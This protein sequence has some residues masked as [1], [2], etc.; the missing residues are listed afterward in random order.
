MIR[1][2]MS[3]ANDGNYR[4]LRWFSAWTLKDKLVDFQL[5]TDVSEIV[6]QISAPFGYAYIQFL[7]T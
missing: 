5:P 4:E 6:S 7:D 1:P 2:K 3:L